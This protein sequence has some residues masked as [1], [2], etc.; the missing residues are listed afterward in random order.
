MFA[1]PA[2]AASVV[3]MA[4]SLILIAGAT[5]VASRKVSHPYA[6]WSA[7]GVLALFVSALLVNHLVPAISHSR[8]IQVAVNR[9][10]SER[11]EDGLKDTPVVYFARDSFAT[12]MGLKDSEVVYFSKEETSAAARF[13]LDHPTAILVTVPEYFDGLEKAICT[14][15]MLDKQ[16]SARHVYLASPV[17]SITSTRIAKGEEE[18]TDR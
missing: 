12:S 9:I 13:L 10:Q 11:S 6:A 18:T 2:H 16:S 3:V 14:S 7:V 8:S 5:A 15:V 17:A 4:A 1:L